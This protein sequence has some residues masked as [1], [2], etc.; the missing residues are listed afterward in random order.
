[1]AQRSFT[2]FFTPWSCLGIA[3]V[4]QPQDT[5]HATDSRTERG[6][7]LFVVCGEANLAAFLGRFRPGQLTHALHALTTVHAGITVLFATLVY[8]FEKILGANRLAFTKSRK[9]RR[10]NLLLNA[11]VAG[12]ILLAV[13]LTAMFFCLFFYWHRR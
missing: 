13:L 3:L 1:M 10:L 11:P 2:T 4:A 8:F 7:A 12:K 5:E 9:F 6:V